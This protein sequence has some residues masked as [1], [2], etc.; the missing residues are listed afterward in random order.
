[1]NTWVRL[2]HDTPA[3]PKWRV[4]AKKSGQ[5]IGDVIAV[6]TFVLTNASANANERGRTHNLVSEDIA[7]ALDL[8][9]DQVD[10]I[11]SAME[12]KVIESGKLSGWEKRNPIKEDGSAERAKA[13]RERKRTQTNATERPN[14][15]DKDTDKIREEKKDMGAPR[16]SSDDFEK[17]RVR[18]PKRGAA[19]PWKPAREKF[20]RLVK[21]GADPGK[22]IIGAEIYARECESSKITGTDK[23]AQAITWLNQERFND[24]VETVDPSK[25]LSIERDMAAR[26]YVWS[27]GKWQKTLE[28]FENG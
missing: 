8:E 24:Y 15:L 26:G 5:R 27:E 18:Y 13:W 11:L 2:Y 17:F 6:W 4:I 25:Q 10:A 19:N 1:M 22:I 21:S 7:G 28:A 20:E 23:V 3:D 12:G 9:P 16:Q 14:A